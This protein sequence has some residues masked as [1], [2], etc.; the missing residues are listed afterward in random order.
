M[1]CFWPLSTELYVFDIIS[2]RFLES[3]ESLQSAVMLFTNAKC[4]ESPCLAILMAII[5]LCFIF[6]QVFIFLLLSSRGTT[7]S[8]TSLLR[9]GW[10]I[11]GLTARRLIGSSGTYKYFIIEKRCFELHFWKLPSL[12]VSFSR[13]APLVCSLTP[14]AAEEGAAQ[15]MSHAAKCILVH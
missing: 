14:P 7:H 4:V 10:R 15:R 1:W 9:A 8:Q 3:R 2:W 12:F 5:G 13:L 6:Q 11:K